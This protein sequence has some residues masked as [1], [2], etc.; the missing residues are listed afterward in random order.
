[1]RRFSRSISFAT[2]GSMPYCS[3]VA[4]LTADA[5]DKLYNCRL[6]VLLAPDLITLIVA[7]C[8]AES[9]YLNADTVCAV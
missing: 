8:Y 7:K 9:L 5:F 3:P 4:F 6:F 2:M 1:M